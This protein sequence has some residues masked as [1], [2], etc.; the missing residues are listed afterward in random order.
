[1]EN[2]G[3]TTDPSVDAVDVAIIG[4]IV[5]TALTTSM[6]TTAAIAKPEAKVKKE[7]TTV[8]R[9]VQNQKR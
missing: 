1:M 8:D 2:V 6:N 9:E 5:D 4:T 3:A 7:V